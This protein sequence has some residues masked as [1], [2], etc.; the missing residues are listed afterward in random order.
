MNQRI[1]KDLEE[2]LSGKEID[3]KKVIHTTKFNRR[4]R[5]HLIFWK[6]WI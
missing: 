5:K 2:W 1:K 6:N 4:L 3:F